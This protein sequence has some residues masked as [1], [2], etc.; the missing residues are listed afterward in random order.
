MS[1]DLVAAQAATM[2]PELMRSLTATPR[3]AAS[4]STQPTAAASNR[5]VEATRRAGAP[6]GQRTDILVNAVRRATDGRPLDPIAAVIEAKGC[7]NPD[8]FIA[9]DQQLV[10]DYMVD[11]RAPV[12][13]FLVGWFDRTEWDPADSRKTRVP[14]LSLAE[15][16]HRL[17]EQAAA[18]PKGFQ[19][20]AVV[21]D[22]R[23]PGA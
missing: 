6:V 1:D 5:E 21:L 10:R 16:Q 20:K 3:C 8:L 17:N 2:D 13:I 23:A 15:T 7:W 18:V 9:L 11:V 14:R 4:A 22:I 19:V 12:G